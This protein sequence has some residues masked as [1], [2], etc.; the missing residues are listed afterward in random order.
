[1]TEEIFQQQ[2]AD[3]FQ[4]EVFTHPINDKNYLTYSQAV[5]ADA[6]T[7]EEINFYIIMLVEQS[8]IQKP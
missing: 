8:S 5:P 4:S 1:M 2:M 7:R 3:I 6:Q